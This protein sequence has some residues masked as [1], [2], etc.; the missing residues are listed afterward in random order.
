MET[1][2][3][4][5]TDVTNNGLVVFGAIVKSTL[6]SK[7]PYSI[8]DGLNEITHNCCIL[9]ASGCPLKEVDCLH[10]RSKVSS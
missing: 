6:I 4:V 5:M 8:Q 9:I 2:C 7:N 10:I 1:R 3:N